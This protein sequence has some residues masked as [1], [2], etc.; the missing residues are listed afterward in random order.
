MSVVAGT[1]SHLFFMITRSAKII[2]SMIIRSALLP[3]L[4]MWKLRHKEVNSLSR[5]HRAY[6]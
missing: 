1:V 3:I 5:G 4:Q 2:R 6:K